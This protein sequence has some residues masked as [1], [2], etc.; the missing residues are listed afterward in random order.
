VLYGGPT[1]FDQKNAAQAILSDFVSTLDTEDFKL[2]DPDVRIQ[3]WRIVSL[4][5]LPILHDGRGSLW[6]Y[7]IFKWWW[8]S[9]SEPAFGVWVGRM[10]GEPVR[11]AGGATTGDV[12]WRPA[13]RAA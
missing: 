1:R 8:S 4:E 13:V 2:Q 9:V 11:V 12:A 10:V 5:M 7:R 6:P 3:N